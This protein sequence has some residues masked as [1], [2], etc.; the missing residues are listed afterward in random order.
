MNCDASLSERPAVLVATDTGTLVLLVHAFSKVTP[1]E[2]KWYIEI[3]R[4]T[5]NVCRTHVKGVCDGMPAYQ[6]D[7]G[8]SPES[9]QETQ[10]LWRNEEADD[11]RSDSEKNFMRT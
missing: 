6:Y 4:Q 1:A 2:K 3:D 9:L 5:G 10:S 11:E 7:N 8:L